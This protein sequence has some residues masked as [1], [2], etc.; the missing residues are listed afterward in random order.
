MVKFHPPTDQHEVFE[1]RRNDYHKFVSFYHQDRLHQL[2][3]SDKIFE[4]YVYDLVSQKVLFQTDIK[5]EKALRD[6]KVIINRGKSV[7]VDYSNLYEMISGDFDTE[8][9]MLRISLDKGVYGVFV[10]YKGLN[11]ISQDGL[12]GDDSYHVFLWPT[13]EHIPKQ[14]V[15]TWRR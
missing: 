12:A 13:A 3:A 14:V 2:V 9:E 7:E 1:F 8:S 5:K 15:K 6:H 10:C 11:T 4:Y